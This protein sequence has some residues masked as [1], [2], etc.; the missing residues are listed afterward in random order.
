MKEELKWF[1]GLKTKYEK[2]VVHQSEGLYSLYNLQ[3]LHWGHSKIIEL[4]LKNDSIGIHYFPELFPVGIGKFK[5]AKAGIDTKI[6][7]WYFV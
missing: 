5:L 6:S 3:I 1:N 7:S 2:Q 4:A